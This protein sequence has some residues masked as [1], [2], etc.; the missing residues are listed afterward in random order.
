MSCISQIMLLRKINLSLI[1]ILFIINFCAS[2]DFNCG[3]SEDGFKSLEFYCTDFEGDLPEN[4]STKF[5]YTLK[6]DDT[7]SKWDVSRLKVGGCNVSNVNRLFYDFPNV[8]EL[9]LS[10]SAIESL[11]SYDIPNNLLKFN[12]SH[13]KLSEIPEGFFENM[14]GIAEVDLSSNELSKMVNLSSTLNFIDISNNNISVMY[15][16]D[17]M[18]TMYMREEKTLRLS[19]NPIEVFGWNL[20]PLMKW[21]YSVF[22]SWEQIVEFKIWTSVHRT[23]KIV[24]N[25]GIEGFFPAEN[26][27]IKFHCSEGSFKNVIRFE[28]INNTIVNPNELVNC[29]GASVE[30]LSLSGNFTESL[31]STVFEPLNS[32]SFERFVN[33]KELNLR[34]AQ[35]LEFDFGLLNKMTT[36][37]RLDISHKSNLSLERINQISAVENATN[38]I[39]L[40]VAENQLE[41]TL[42]MIEHLNSS[43][44]Y[45]NLN[46]NHVGKVKENTF[47]KLQT[48]QYLYLINTNILLDDVKPFNPLVQLKILDISHNYLKNIDLSTPIS[49]MEQLRILKAADCQIANASEFIKL[50]TASVQL[51]EL[52]LSGNFLEQ[53][54]DETFSIFTELKYLN[55][56]RT[57]LTVIDFNIFQHNH[58]LKT[59]DLSFNR[60][61]RLDFY[62]VLSGLGAIHL[63]R[64]ILTKIDHLTKSRFSELDYI[65]ISMNRFSCG[66][67]ES[68]LKNTT[69]EFQFLTIIGNSLKQNGGKNCLPNDTEEV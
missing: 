32:T 50:F 65:D 6:T 47:A 1:V 2:N 31:N 38:L 46:G 40:N 30:Y 59:L 60:I 58:D 61:K 15:Q 26:N 42:E 3:Y 54:N 57:H 25:S 33:L 11:D 27:T 55:L 23:I 34:D 37:E 48:L 20:L 67:L 13:N 62:T 7:F 69:N 43:I 51:S 19:G 8:S 64:N 16:D 24:S 66:F 28:F 41:S 44:V 22:M 63:Q 18:A 4:C 9:D 52:D 49:S 10:Q 29:V 56:S 53:V 17:K 12:A 21:A 5:L 36:I 45:L 35:L 14:L 39:Y 68:F